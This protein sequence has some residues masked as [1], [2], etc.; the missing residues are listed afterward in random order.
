M[1]GEPAAANNF[2]SKRN[3]LTKSQEFQDRLD[4]SETPQGRD[5]YERQREKD[6][7]AVEKMQQARS[8]RELRRAE[9]Q[10]EREAKRDALRFDREM[11]SN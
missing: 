3:F 6:S 2:M 11:R 7:R 4:F 10:W 9:K 1:R 5:F 8:E